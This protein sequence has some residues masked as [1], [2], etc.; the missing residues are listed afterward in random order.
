MSIDKLASFLVLGEILSIFSQSVL[1]RA[2]GLQS[3]VLITLRSD[4]SSPPFYRAFIMKGCE[5][6][7]RLFLHPLNGSVVLILDSVYI[8]DYVHFLE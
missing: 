2:I 7:P 8:P 6:L 1:T 3:L 5:F 4:P